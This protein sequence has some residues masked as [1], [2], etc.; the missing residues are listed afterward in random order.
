MRAL[1]L[2]PSPKYLGPNL[3][4]LGDFF[5]KFEPV[6]KRTFVTQASSVNPVSGAQE[7][8]PW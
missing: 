8:T 3:P 5:G 6:L 7:G 2:G 1:H 4:T